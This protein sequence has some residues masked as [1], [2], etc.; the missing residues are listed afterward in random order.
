MHHIHLSNVCISYRA[1]EV[2]WQK[3]YTCSKVRTNYIL[4]HWTIKNVTFYFWL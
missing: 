1:I 4:T 2:A 3:F